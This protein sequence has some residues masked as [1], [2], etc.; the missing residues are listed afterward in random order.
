MLILR[1]RLSFSKISNSIL[2]HFGG[3]IH[4]SP[5]GVLV[6]RIHPVAHFVPVGAVQGVRISF[7]PLWN[8][9]LT[10]ILVLVISVVQFAEPASVPVL[11]LKM[12]FQIILS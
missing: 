3:Y 8:L 9:V 7:R 10:V 11:A 6:S 12:L 2:S 5:G 1:R 4:R